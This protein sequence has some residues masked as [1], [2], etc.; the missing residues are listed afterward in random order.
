MTFLKTARSTALV[1]ACTLCVA[2]PFAQ[3]QPGSQSDGQGGRRHGPPPEA[4]DA[5]ADQAEGAACEFPGFRGETVEG[6][7]IAPP[8][9]DDELV[10]AP[11]GGPPHQG[12]HGRDRNAGFDRGQ[13]RGDG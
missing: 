8:G 1:L 5:C 13:T 7:C 12:S 4:I 11:E 6:T 9:R 10:C 3:A 2:A